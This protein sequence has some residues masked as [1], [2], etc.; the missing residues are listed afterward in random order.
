VEQARFE[1]TEQTTR[2][3]AEPSEVEV[4][5]ER[6][7]IEAV[8]DLMARALMAVVRAAEEATDER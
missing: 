2:G 6:E 8:I 3:A 7:T 4:E 5:L 1:W